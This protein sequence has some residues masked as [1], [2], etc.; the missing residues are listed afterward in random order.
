[1]VEGE[2]GA[3]TRFENYPITQLPSYPIHPMSTIFIISAPSGSGKS[4]LVTSVRSAVADLDF[5]IS[6]TT[7]PPRGSERNGVE[8]FFVTREE[9]ER[10]IARGEFLEYA[11]V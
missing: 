9:F 2:S 3:V 11:D 6:Y 4:T 5:S 10:M 8:Y 1:M 7:R